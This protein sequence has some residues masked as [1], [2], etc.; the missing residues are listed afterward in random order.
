MT[1]QLRSARVLA[2]PPSLHMRHSASLTHSSMSTRPGRPATPAACSAALTAKAGALKAWPWA[3]RM[4]WGLRECVHVPCTRGSFR[5][6][7]T[8]QHPCVTW[9]SSWTS[10]VQRGLSVKAGALNARPWHAAWALASASACSP[11]CL[12]LAAHSV[13]PRHPPASQQPQHPHV[14]WA[15]SCTIVKQRGSDRESRRPQR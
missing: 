10:G 3:W 8:P 1:H 13:S 14:A 6:L 7:H 9:A 5:Q 11:P 12:A 15:S 2:A 4:G